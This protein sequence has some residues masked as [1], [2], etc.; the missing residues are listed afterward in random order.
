MR[1]IDGIH[2]ERRKSSAPESFGVQQK[3]RRRRIDTPQIEVCV[4]GGPDPGRSTRRPQDSRPRPSRG[5]PQGCPLLSTPP[6]AKV[7]RGARSTA[8]GMTEP[9]SGVPLERAGRA[10]AVLPSPPPPGPGRRDTSMAAPRE[11]GQRRHALHSVCRQIRPAA[12]P[13]NGSRHG[14][15]RPARPARTST[16]AR[17]QLCPHLTSR[18]ARWRHD[19]VHRPHQPAPNADRIAAR[20]AQKHSAIAP[21]ASAPGTAAQFRP[22]CPDASAPSCVTPVRGTRAPSALTRGIP[23]DVP[24]VPCSPHSNPTSTAA[25]VASRASQ[26]RDETPPSPRPCLERP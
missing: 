20:L 11:R 8:C 4:L 21:G 10:C 16:R 14:R 26:I 7:I 17:L 23:G 24:R 2:R 25:A 22:P 19:G 13:N 3:E 1:E 15:Y 18:A 12:L 9:L 6:P 5:A